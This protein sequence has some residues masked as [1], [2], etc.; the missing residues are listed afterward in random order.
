MSRAP[1]LA[2]SERAGADGSYRFDGEIGLPIVGRL[3][4]YRGRLRPI[5][6]PRF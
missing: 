6:E 2:A 4:R 1:R 3:V 5:S